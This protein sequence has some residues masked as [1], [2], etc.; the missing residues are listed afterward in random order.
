MSTITETSLQHELLVDLQLKSWT[1]HVSRITQLLNL[2]S[3][4]ALAREIAPGKN[5][6]TY[7]L[8][9][10][11][12]VNDGMRKLMGLG[13]SLYPQ[14]T[15]PFVTSSDKSGNQFPAITELKKAWTHVNDELAKG[16]QGMRLSDWLDRHTSVSAEDFAREPHRNKLNIV[17]SRTSHLAYHLGQL[18]LL[19]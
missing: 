2:L 10:L 1:T 8:G 11:V 12:A 7:I 17:I 15:E 13:T 3:D 5:T 4:E 14:Y 9:H 16:F 19:K 18:V 6:G